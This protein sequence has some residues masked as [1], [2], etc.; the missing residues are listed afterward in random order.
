MGFG[1]RIAKQ[2]AEVFEQGFGLGG[3]GAHQRN[4]AVEGVEQ[5]VRSYA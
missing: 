2:I 3:L 5:K 1:Q 4:R